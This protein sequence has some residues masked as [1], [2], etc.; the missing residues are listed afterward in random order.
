VRGL[1]MQGAASIYADTVEAK[2]MRDSLYAN[3]KV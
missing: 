1:C 3:A 2:G